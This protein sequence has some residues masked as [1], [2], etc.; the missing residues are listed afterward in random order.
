MT[1][2]RPR[3]LRAPI[4][5]TAAAAMVASLVVLPTTAV[6]QEDAPPN[7]VENGD[8]ST[9]TYEP[10]WGLEDATIADGQACISLPAGGQFG[11]WVDLG[12]EEGGSYRFGFTVSGDP[13][14]EGLEAR[15]Q[16]DGSDPLVADVFETFAVS[17]TPEAHVVT[18]TAE[19][20]AQRVQFAAGSADA[21]ELCISDV[22][23]TPLAELL[24]NPGFQP[25]GDGYGAWWTAGTSLADQDG[26][27]CAEVPAGGDPWNVIVG[28]DG[29]DVE[30]GR[31]YTVTVTASA[32]PEANAR[33]VIPEP[34]V[35]WPNVYEAAIRLRADGQSF[36]DTFVSEHTGT[37][38]F[39]LQ[40]GGNEQPFEVCLELASLTTGGTVTGY[41]PDTG[42]RV[43]VNQVGYL[44]EGPKRA[45]LVSDATEPLPWELHDADGATVATGTSEPR[46]LDPS[47]GLEVHVLDLTAFTGS[48]E[49]FT[50]V[51]DGET[52]Y[53]FDIS[54]TLYDGLRRDALGIYYSQRSGIEI[55]DE[56]KP[57]YGRPAGHLSPFG[58][59]DVNQGDLDVP[60]LPN[61]R[62]TAAGS[63]QRGGFDHYGEDGWDCP[64]GYQLDLSGGWYDAGDHGKYVVN[65]GISVWQL[66]S[67]YERNQL[68]AVADRE[69]LGDGTLAIP[70]A[71]NGTPDIL[72]EVRWNLEWM[73]KMQVPAGT[74]MSI[75]G[76][77]LDAGGLVHHKLHDIAW[78]GMNTFPH[79]DPMLR[80]VHRPSTAATLN[81]AAAA[82]QGARLYDEHDPAFAA[83]L[84]DAARRAWDAAQA[85]PDILAPN[86]NDLDPNPGGGPYDDTQVSDEFYWAAAQ[87][88]LTTGGQP[89]LDVVLGS[90]HHAPDWDETAAFDWGNVDAAARLDLATVPSDLP[91]REQVIDWVLEGADR[92]LEIQDAQPF[93]HPYGPEEYDWGSTHQVIN[94]A[95]VIATAYD[96]TGDERYLD[97]AIEAID[98]VLG[99]NALNNS[100]VTSYGTS[101]SQNMHSR[102]YSHS[103]T[104]RM[105]PPPPGKVAGGPN[106][107]IQ[108]PIAQ[109]NLQGCAPQL[110]YI[111]DLESWSTNET[112]INW[113]AA[114][115][116]HASWLSDV[117]DGAPEH[118]GRDPGPVD[119]PPGDGVDCRRFTD[120]PP[121]SNPHRT[122]IC[123][124]AAD[125]LIVGFPDG[126]FGPRRTVTRGQ[127]ASVL[128]RWGG[129]EPLS[130]ATPTFSDTAGSPHAG[131]IE[132]LR[133][134]GVAAG[135]EDGTFRPN[136]PVRRDQ[137][138]SLLARWLELGDRDTPRFDDVGA[139]SPHARSIAALAH[140][141]I[142]EGREDGRFDPGGPLRRDQFAS[143][144]HRAQLR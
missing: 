123:A 53:P 61:E 89:Y 92:Y 111:D 60:C 20:G 139:D 14:T 52:S 129:L 8:F 88:Y 30:E 34:G 118:P 126:T 7:L 62:F 58:G 99:R 49:G 102:W 86:T 110:C 108:D 90:P 17:P 78:T 32:S 104:D 23:V 116:W 31:T 12:L 18:F 46:G 5:L 87:L 124:L 42:P 79:E 98:Y 33:I 71:G 74:Q 135:F 47:A 37:T 83:E 128:A 69:A 22:F 131:A 64:E 134:R 138:A 39:Q 45:T 120:L 96:L 55:L 132:A 11:N 130:P 75:D 2:P 72:D 101:Y 1:G 107:G 13:A 112:T 70:E 3:P 84:L 76:D 82:A 100:Y 113:N 44:P 73:L 54:A 65:S 125:G 59:E 27:A 140:L 80:F 109:R 63:T 38:K 50:L 97:G 15:I 143:L 91:G 57:G 144:V 105:P 43:R 127:M 119:P 9:G 115:A 93:G 77:E 95:V 141:G 122:S 94:N 40:L 85:H 68:A 121:T 36:S 21:T 26:V 67:T 103:I 29:F 142:I 117:G 19:T 10:W 106:S 114:L 41:E 136:L 6:A 133:A 51:T 25:V 4:A 56:I 48:G 137:A 28:Q 35:D 81:L 66:L 24:D 16:V